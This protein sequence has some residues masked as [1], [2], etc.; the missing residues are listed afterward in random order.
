MT[1]LRRRGGSGDGGG[2]GRPSSRCG[3]VRWG[4][5]GGGQQRQRESLT[6][7]QLREW[8]TSRGGGGGSSG[9]HSAAVQLGV[10]GGGLTHLQQRPR[11]TLTPQQLREWY[12][13]RGASPSSTRCPYVIRTGDWAGQTCGTVGHTQ[14]RCFSYLSD[15]WHAEFGDATE[16]PRWLEL[17]RQR[18]DI[19][20]LDYDAILTA[21]YALSASAEGDCSQCVPPDPGVAALALGASAS[22][23]PPGTAPAEALRSFTLDSGTSRCFFRDSTTL[24]PLPAPV[25]VRLADPSKGP[26]IAR[27]STKLPCPAIPSGSL[28]GLHLPSFSTKLV[29]T[30]A[31][32]DAIVTITNPGGQPIGTLLLR[33]KSRI[34]LT[35]LHEFLEV[36]KSRYHLYNLDTECADITEVDRISLQV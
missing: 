2:G 30:A 13:Q 22:D 9:S 36:L 34:V 25:P 11:E 7:Q 12:V 14:S 32:Q 17:A 23:T 10:P 28:S 33:A 24:T 31:L 8:C 16:L 18:V 29:S 5:S 19:F 15:T 6:P 26:V 35:V 21:M 27:S 4:A 1:S 20:A 3:A